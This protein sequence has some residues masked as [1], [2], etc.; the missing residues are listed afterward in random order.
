LSSKYGVGAAVQLTVYD[1]TSGNGL[2]HWLIASPYG[3]HDIAL[4]DISGLVSDF[5]ALPPGPVV[6]SV[7][8]GTYDATFDYAKLRYRHM[9]PAGMAAYATD[10]FAAH[11][12]P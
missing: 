3:D 6:I 1:I 5:G 12:D 10:T 2:M 4:P 11:I 7:T 8:G 9:R